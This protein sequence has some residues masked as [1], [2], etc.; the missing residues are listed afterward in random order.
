MTISTCSSSASSS[1]QGDAL[2]NCRGPA[3]HHFDLLAAQSPR[4][5]AAIH[6]GIAH[7]DDQDVFADGIGVA[8]GDRIE[9]VDTDVD[10]VGIVA[11]GNVEILTA[12]RARADE[13]GIEAC[14]EQRLHAGDRRVVMNLDAAVENHVDLF[15]EDVFRQ[16]ERR[17]VRP[18]QTAGLVE[19]LE[20]LDLIAERQQV[21][22]DGERCGT[23]ADQRDAFAVLLFREPVGGGARMSPR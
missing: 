2:K 6:R 19:L 8:E 9:P 15:V 17:N 20:D 1:S 18:H 13:D 16:P 7:A 3:R 4:G 12:R 11:P 23:G 21:I 14:G 22:G 5:A 10:A